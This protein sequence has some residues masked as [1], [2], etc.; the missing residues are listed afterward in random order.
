MTLKKKSAVRIFIFTLILFSV[1]S[2]RSEIFASEGNHDA[3]FSRTTLSHWDTGT[4]PN[5]EACARYHW[6]KH[7]AYLGK[8]PE[9]YTQDALQF[10]KV[11]KGRARSLKLKNGE[12]GYVIRSGPGGPGGYFTEDGRI[13]SFWYE[14]SRERR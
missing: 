14:Y 2:T 10:F 13:V 8:T 12:P 6:E 9:E 7:A 1:L 3:I 11:E 5:A 4:F